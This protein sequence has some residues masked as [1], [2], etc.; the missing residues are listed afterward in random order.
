MVTVMKARM[1]SLVP[2]PAGPAA[3]AGPRGG[4]ARFVALELAVWSALYGTYLAVRGITMGS[5]GEAFSHAWEVVDLERT[6]GVF[7]ESSVQQ[8]LQPVADVFSVYYMVG[9]GPVIAAVSIWLGLRD[10]AAYRALRNA[11]LLSIAI[12]TV[13][14]VFFPTAPPRLVGGLAIED[15]VGLSSH[16][17]GS[18]LGIRFNPYA[19]VPSMHVGWSLLVAV[20]AFRATRRRLLRV[21]FALHPLL[22]AITVTATGNHYF[23]DSVGGVLVACLTLGLLVLGRRHRRRPPLRALPPATGDEQAAEP[24]RRAA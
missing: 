10:R 12:A 16:D 2:A 20:F 13:V 1:L 8:L 24:L 14:F 3:P 22:M 6:L 18:F 23:L 19:A 9:F 5:S 21:C 4:W 11:L 7:R 15:T 17:T